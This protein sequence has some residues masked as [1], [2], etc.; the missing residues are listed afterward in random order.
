[1]FR[2]GVSYLRR[3]DIKRG[4]GAKNTQEKFYKVKFVKIFFDVMADQV[5]NE[6]VDKKL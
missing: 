5:Q 2:E 4:E 6:T 1:M 3:V